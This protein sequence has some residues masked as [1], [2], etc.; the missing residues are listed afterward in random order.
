MTI[1]AWLE[2][3]AFGIGAVGCVIAGTRTGLHG[4]FAIAA[5]AVI[6]GLLVVWI[7]GRPIT[8]GAGVFTRRAR[9]IRVVL[10]ALSIALLLWGIVLNVT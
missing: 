2:G 9:A 8:P 5:A 6:L 7:R 1:G 10:A 4:Y 3:V